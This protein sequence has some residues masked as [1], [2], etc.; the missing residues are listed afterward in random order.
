MIQRYVEAMGRTSHT[1]TFYE[2]AAFVDGAR[3][4]APMFTVVAW[5][6]DQASPLR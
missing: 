5:R 1:T 4:A 6:P 3:R 2:T